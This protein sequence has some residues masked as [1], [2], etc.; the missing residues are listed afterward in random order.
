MYKC[1]LLYVINV[2]SDIARPPVCTCGQY[3]YTLTSGHTLIDRA[4]LQNGKMLYGALSYYSIELCP[5]C[6]MS[7][8]SIEVALCVSCLLTL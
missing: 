2:S 6:G 1:T 7:G 5:V 3:I 4:A 8:Y